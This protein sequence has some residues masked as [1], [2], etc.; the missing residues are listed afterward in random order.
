MTGFLAAS[1]F[2]LCACS[3]DKEPA[4]EED[5][6]AAAEYR[7][8]VVLP[9]QG[10]AW[11]N[12]IDWSLQNLNDA[13]GELRQIEVTA[14]WFDEETEN[15][16]QLFETLASRADL[17]AVIGPLY[18]RNADIAARQ[19]YRTGKTL[20]LPTVSSETVMRKYSQSPTK[21][22]WCLTESDI[23]QCEILLTRAQQK[24]AK[25]VSLL[26]SDDAYGATFSDW[27]AFQAEEMGLK[28]GSV[29]RYGRDNVTERMNGLLSEDTDCLICVPGDAQ[30]AALMNECRIHRTNTRPFLLFSDIAFIAASGPAY[31]GMEGVS[32]ISDPQSGFR[33]AHEVK[34]G[35]APIYGSARFFDAVTLAGLAILKSDLAGSAD[36]NTAFR[37]IVDGAGSEINGSS[38]TGIRRAAQY[39]IDGKSFHLTGA[40]G[41]LYFDKEHYTNVIHS[42]YCH[43]QIYQGQPLILEYNTSDDSK[44]TDGSAANWNW[45]VTRMQDFNPYITIY[46]PPRE[47][48]YAIVVAPA[49]GWDNY[50]YQANAYAVYRL[51]RENG[52]DDDRILLVSEDDIAFDPLNPTPGVIASPIDGGNLFEGV[53]VDYRPS[54]LSFRDLETAVTS[55]TSFRPGMKDNLFVYWAGG[56][57]PEGPKWLDEVI[58]CSEVA[59]FFRRLSSENRFR[60]LFLAM[61]ADYAGRVGEACADRRIPGMLCLTA[62][63]ENE[64]S[65]AT[66]IDASGQVW[67]S[68]YF[69]DALLR[70]LAAD[71]EISVY[72]LYRNVYMRTVGSH[73]TVCNA[74]YF[75]NLYDS[76]VG[77]FLK[78]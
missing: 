10:A 51:L 68:S 34:F 52:V 25:K 50:R 53:K 30:V 8:A 13:L 48:L 17:S 65:K 43:W 58:P 14:E 35:E 5:K 33:V 12:T 62:T 37:Q 18:S 27:F 20:I 57:V 56:G 16:E 78:P 46:Y 15:L 77:E 42:V 63:G 28:T 40:S 4:I 44:R 73:V 23:S 7:I 69:T 70:Q 64:T 74:D 47:E 32:P 75:G 45:K 1:L 49:S 71:G 9:R 61:D 6:P 72:D 21:F 67:A 59:D 66:C 54:E 26:T 31:E 19:C 55:G 41:R 38:A 60:K 3:K 39:L 24:G 36:V 2:L 22:L 29:E 11:K 76:S